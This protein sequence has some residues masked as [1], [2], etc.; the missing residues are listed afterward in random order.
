M[1]IRPLAVIVDQF[2][3]RIFYD[4]EY[5]NL[6]LYDYAFLH[7]VTFFDHVV[8]PKTGCCQTN[9]NSHRTAGTV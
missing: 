1:A 9:E 5:D 8:N 4:I 6:T 7:E 2:S 3:D